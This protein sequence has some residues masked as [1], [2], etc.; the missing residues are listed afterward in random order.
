MNWSDLVLAKNKVKESVHKK[1]HE[2][3]GSLVRKLDLKLN[4]VEKA[5]KICK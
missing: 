5:R 3:C 1:V 4:L 2:S